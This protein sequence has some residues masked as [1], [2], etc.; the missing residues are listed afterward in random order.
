MRG[1]EGRANPQVYLSSSQV[2]DDAIIGYVPRAL[3]VRSTLRPE[4]L[5]ASIRSIVT[6]ADATMPVAEVSTLAEIV[7]RDTASRSTQLR[8]IGIFALIACALAGVGIHGLL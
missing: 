8:V 1:L 5:T 7:E 2:G 4:T 3:V 6:R